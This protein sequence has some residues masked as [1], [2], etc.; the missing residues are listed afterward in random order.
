M[1]RPLSSLRCVVLLLSM[2][3]AAAAAGPATGPTTGT[4]SADF[5]L[6]RAAKEIRASMATTRPA[7]PYY[8]QQL[9]ELR[10]SEADRQ[11]L[12]DVA[13]ACEAKA[14]AGKPLARLEWMT[15]AAV[16]QGLAGDRQTAR[17][18]AV[19]ADSLR[20]EVPTSS[21]SRPFQIDTAAVWTAQ[22]FAFAG[23]L[24][25]AA[26]LDSDRESLRF[27]AIRLAAAHRREDAL[28]TFDRWKRSP[29]PT[30][31]NAAMQEVD[32]DSADIDAIETL[33]AMG[34]LGTAE[35]ELGR[36]EP[37]TQVFARMAVAHAYW[38]SGDKAGYA[39]CCRVAL[40]DADA[41]GGWAA[42]ELAEIATEAARIHDLDL[43][44][45][46]NELLDKCDLKTANR[47]AIIARCQVAMGDRE[48]FER[49]AA[50]A[51]KH[52]SDRRLQIERW[53]DTLA[54]AAAHA[55]A[56]NK[57]KVEELL[58]QVHPDDDAKMILGVSYKEIAEA[59][60]AGGYYDSAKQVLADTR[61][62]YAPNP[63]VMVAS[64]MARA[65]DIAG[66]RREFRSVKP[67]FAMVEEMALV[68]VRA[69]RGDEAA[70][71]VDELTSPSQRAGCNLSLACELLGRG[72]RS[73]YRRELQP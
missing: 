36:L 52:R 14:T 26:Q 8:T 60:A 53:E 15:D 73:R 34:E 3:P 71:L 38:R 25:R 27:L 6:D 66:A 63:S 55:R 56:G 18:L 40:A 2:L 24:D 58:K 12:L 9:Y 67:T 64:Y 17:Q 62:Q 49:T 42:Y 70:S 11:L 61:P 50:F 45:R 16:C 21:T 59:Y 41:A 7:A 54:L 1:R 30:T 10:G 72:W 4:S 68:L 33:A 65:G 51:E 47:S 32:R 5:W 35:R 20:R 46:V 13:R 31:T 37:G 39:R 69:G 48:R 22:A 19:R 28:R 44:A 57:D 29:R 23:D 43:M